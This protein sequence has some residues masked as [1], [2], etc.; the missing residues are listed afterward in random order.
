MV[1]T[2]VQH[3]NFVL[4]SFGG[5]RPAVEVADKIFHAAVRAIRVID[6]DYQHPLCLPCSPHP[7]PEKAW[8]F[9]NAGRLGIACGKSAEIF[10]AFQVRRAVKLNFPPCNGSHYPPAGTFVP[11]NMR[12]P[13][14]RVWIGND[15][16]S[17]VFVKSQSAVQAVRQALAL[18]VTPFSQIQVMSKSGHQRVMARRAEPAGIAEIVRHAAG[19]DGPQRIRAKRYGQRLPPDKVPRAGM[20]PVHGAWAG[21]GGII[22]II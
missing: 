19:K 15:R 11:K 2:G 12:V 18:P 7:R 17:G 14:I 5:K 8:A 1:H 3:P 16:V 13:E 20:P 9:P 6:A 22:L 21:I 4:R 10:P